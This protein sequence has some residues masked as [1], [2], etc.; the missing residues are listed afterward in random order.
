M[1]QIKIYV[2]G[3]FNAG[4]TTLIHKLAPNATSIEHYYNDGT[5]TTVGFDLGTIYWDPT[6]DKLLKRIPNNMEKIDEIYK[7]VLVGTPGQMQFAPVRE[8]LAK[9]CQGVLFIIDSTNLGQVGVALA[10]YEEIKSYF[11]GDFPMII[12]AN[13]QDL[14]NAADAETIGRLLKIENVKIIEGSA[15]KEINIEEAIIELL[16]MIV[17]RNS[18]YLTVKAIS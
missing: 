2:T 14:E 17:N 4:K 1:K 11:K 6:N 9:G 5:S 7:V 8:I 18:E 15:L 13:K 10:M 3:P 12:L 16:H